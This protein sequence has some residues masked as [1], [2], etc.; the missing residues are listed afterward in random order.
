MEIRNRINSIAFIHEKLY[1]VK[2][3]S[4]ISFPAYLK[5]LTDN[6]ILSYAVNS[7]NIRFVMDV[8]DAFVSLDLAVPCGLIVN[9]LVSNCLK[10]AFPPDEK[11]EIYI[12]FSSNGKGRY[13]LIAGNRGSRITFPE[14]LDFR[15]AKTLG[16]QLVCT[17]TSQLRGEISLSRLEGTEFC[18]TFPGGSS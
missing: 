4:N 9:E 18:I 1:Q 13:T 17:L 3:Y 16:L 2:N 10:H 15:Q 14:N 12:K 6:L 8:E 5:T 7:D 11:G